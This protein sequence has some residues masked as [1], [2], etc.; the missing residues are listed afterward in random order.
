MPD[1]ATSSDL[2]ACPRHPRNTAEPVLCIPCID[3]VRNAI[4]RLPEQ[5]RQLLGVRHATPNRAERRSAGG[6]PPS[7]NRYFDHADDIERTLRH[8]A[9]GWAELTGRDRNDHGGPAWSARTLLDQRHGNPLT[10][11]AAP[12]LATAVLALHRQAAVLLRDEEPRAR[13]AREHISGV[14]GGCQHA[15]LYRTADSIL[16]RCGHCPRTMTNQ[17]YRDYTEGVIAQYRSRVR[18]TATP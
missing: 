3:N 2:P 12:D 18:Q 15:Y 9:N 11:P 7:Q 13:P 8:W 10:H 4:W 14:C 5:H 1:T 16:V 6:P 17:E